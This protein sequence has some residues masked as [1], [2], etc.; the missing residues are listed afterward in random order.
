MRQRLEAWHKKV[1][2]AMPAKVYCHCWVNINGYL[3]LMRC[4][5]YSRFKH[6][7]LRLPVSLIGKNSF[8]INLKYISL[9]STT[10]INIVYFWIVHLQFNIWLLIC[11]LCGLLKA[12]LNQS[13]GIF[14]R[15]HLS[16]YQR[17]VA[18]DASDGLDE[19]GKDS[20][21]E[22]VQEVDMRRGFFSC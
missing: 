18:Q 21:Y 5:I 10:S 20:T 16:D 14:S 9:F 13:P 15:N 11:F 19:N 6:H 2:W 8:D 12:R 4:F 1:R 7:W 17:S 3:S 22:Y